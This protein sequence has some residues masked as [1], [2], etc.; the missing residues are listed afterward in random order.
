MGVQSEVARRFLEWEFKDLSLKDRMMDLLDIVLKV[1]SSTSE[2][3]TV[4]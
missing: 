1:E 4:S 2:Y 3:M